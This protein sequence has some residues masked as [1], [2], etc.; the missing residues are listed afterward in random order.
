MTPAVFCILIAAVM[1]IVCAGLAKARAWGVPRRDG[2]YD[3][4]NPRD[5]LAK[6]EG[7]GKW[8]DAAQQNCWEALPFFAAAVIIS[9]ML[10]VVGTLPNT[11]ALSFIALRVVYVWLYVT[12]RQMQRSL[13]WVAA[14]AVNV[15]IF[16]LPAF[17]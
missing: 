8:A 1:P 5:W 3:N 16:L 12:G 4:R 13:V 9:H 2:G 14:F 15:A 7:F 10:G 6:Q 11:L 17:K